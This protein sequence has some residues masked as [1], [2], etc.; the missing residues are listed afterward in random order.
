MARVLKKNEIDL[1]G[2]RM[3]VKDGIRSFSTN[4]YPAKI[5]IGDTNKDSRQRVSS[6]AL[7]D[8]RGGIGLN[9]YTGAADVDRAWF[10][11]NQLRFNGNIVL[12]PLATLTADSGQT[13]VF[14]VSVIGQLHNTIYATFGRDVYAYNDSTDSWGSSLDTMPGDP[15]SG[16]T[17]RMNGTVYFIIF[18][19]TGYVYTSDGATWTD[20]TRD[21]KYGVSWDDRL[22]AIDNTGQMWF[23]LS[24]GTEFTEAQLPLEDGDVTGLVTGF[25]GGGGQ[26][27]IFAATK[28]GLYA[29]DVDQAKFIQTG[30]NLSRHPSGGLGSVRWRD[31]IYYP[32]GLS[33]YK[34]AAGGTGAVVSIIGPDRDDGL[35]SAYRGT[36]TQLLPTTNELLALVDSA[37]TIG[38]RTAYSA[39]AMGG[40][41]SGG[42]GNR[43][44]SIGGETGF[45]MIIGN[46]EIGWEVKWVSTS[47]STGIDSAFV[48]DAYG[49]YR[50]WWAANQRVYFMTLPDNIINPNEVTNFDYATDGELITPWF[51]AGQQDVTKLALK[52]KGEL[53]GM[54][55]TETIVVSYGLD[56]DENTWVIMDDAWNTDATATTGTL[57]ADGKTTFTFPSIATPEGLPFKFIRFRFQHA[58]GS[59]STKVTPKLRHFVLEWRK[60]LETT[61]G[62]QFT[63]LFN[64]IKQALTP[65]ALRAALITALEKEE[66]VAFTFRNDDDDILTRR[67]YVDVVSATGLEDTGIDETG[68]SVVTVLEPN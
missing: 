4:T 2:I 35:P 45:N 65:K 46:D 57:T 54:S 43:A 26:A 50:L 44:R 12:P 36:I 37:T 19:S 47:T 56:L 38:S 1:N 8:F 52:A 63:V 13:G 11:T 22:W 62:W 29:H 42:Q 6:L 59:S 32:A 48:G 23:A 39:H 64:D 68:E 27:I 10:A 60:K 24:P 67:P 40:W 18:Y 3:K 7:T 14:S 34:Y 5:V 66:L 61:Y 15:V 28:F 16:L 33:I 21:A 41:R 31:N 30:L 51:D 53:L 9:R 25:P 58:R 20:S 49:K 17:I 55:A